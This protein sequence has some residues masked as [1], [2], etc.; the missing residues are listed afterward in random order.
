MQV[1]TQEQTTQMTHLL[2]VH[3]F[4]EALVRC[5]VGGDLIELSYD[6]VGG[7]FDWYL[8]FCVILVSPGGLLNSYYPWQQTL[9]V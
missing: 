8:C 6:W 7:G 1:V 3:L 4:L 9:E 5:S 2:A